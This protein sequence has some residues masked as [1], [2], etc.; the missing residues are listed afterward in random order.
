M[1]PS[2]WSYK[3]RRVRLGLTFEFETV[4]AAMT[5][6]IVDMKIDQETEGRP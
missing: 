4:A 2:G 6:S 1:T 5:G 3:G